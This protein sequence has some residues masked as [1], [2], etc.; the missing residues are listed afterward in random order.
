[1]I[2]VRIINASILSIGL[3]LSGYFIANGLK[4][5]R[6]HDRSVEVKGL[7]EHTMKSDEAIWTINIKLVN[8][9]LP[10]L[11]QSIDDAQKKMKQ[12]LEKQGFVAEE[13]ITNPVSV[14]D[15]QSIGYNQ[16][17]NIPRY[18]A[19][20]GLTISTKRI[21]PVAAAIQKTGELIEQGVVVTTSSAIYRFNGLNQIKPQMLTE[22]TQSAHAAA[23]SFANNAKAT[24]GSIRRATQGLF[25]ITDA[26]STYDSG[27]SIMKKIRVVTSIDYELEE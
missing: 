25:T 3:A 22:A 13:I 21:D 14:T 17:L 9:E 5:S 4:E 23:Q 8:G 6:K 20:T 12:F 19:D 27:T 11:Y 10:A 26:N 16:S 18:S 1:M 7:A 24:L 2:N 15:N